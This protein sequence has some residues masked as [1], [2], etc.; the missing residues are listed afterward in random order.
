MRRLKQH[1]KSTKH[2]NFVDTAEDICMRILC[3]TGENEY[4]LVLAEE[5][6][7]G[8][9]Q[10][11]ATVT[12]GSNKCV[13]VKKFIK[14][15][16]S[17]PMSKRNKTR[18]KRLER[19][20]KITGMV[21]ENIFITEEEIAENL[22]LDVSSLDSFVRRVLGVG[23]KKYLQTYRDLWYNKHKEMIEVVVDW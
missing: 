1:Q 5:I 8:M 16:I 20:K 9:I 3:D 13:D 15:H 10:Y 14:H 21:Q 19:M 2:N 12:G 4:S 6:E 18:K 17:T 23:V 11:F 22:G 7:K